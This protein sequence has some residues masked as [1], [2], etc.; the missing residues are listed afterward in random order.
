MSGEYY[1]ANS[2]LR[3]GNDKLIL[4]GIAMNNVTSSAVTVNNTAVV[5]PATSLTGRKSILILNNSTSNV[6][7]GS[8]TV[9]TINGFLLYP[10]QSILLGIGD[11]IPIYAISTAGA[12]ADL[13]I[14]EGA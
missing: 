1:Q 6:Y 10:H 5:L 7:I 3:D 14:L 4:G 2:G 9:S 12:N 13:R 8:S 11:S